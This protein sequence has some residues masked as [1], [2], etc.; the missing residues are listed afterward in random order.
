MP[1]GRPPVRGLEDLR[2][3]LT[4][5]YEGD[6]SDE[7]SFEYRTHSLVV[8]GTQAFDHGTLELRARGSG[9][10]EDTVRELQYVDSYRREP[11][12]T[13]KLDTAA[14]FPPE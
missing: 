3:F 1:P 11:D 2:A 6:E 10:D 13:W 9:S 4:D 5:V 14:W 12:G 7:R 8:R